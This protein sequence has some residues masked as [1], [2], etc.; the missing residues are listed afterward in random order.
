MDIRL[1][2]VGHSYGELEVVR[3]IDLEIPE[4]RFVCILGPSGCGKSTLLRF[5][6]GLECPDVGQ[7]LQIGDPP[8]GCLNPL[9]YIFQDFA[10]L[11]WRTVYGNVSLVLEDHDLGG[12]TAK[13]IIDDVLARTKLSDFANALPRQLSG[14]M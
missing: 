13:E 8:E 6:G 5:L 10:L 12:A 3:D 11:P 4:C 7:V 9:T 2:G 1:Q 14:G